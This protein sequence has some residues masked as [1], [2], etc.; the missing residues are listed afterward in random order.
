[1]FLAHALES[2]EDDGARLNALPADVV[3]YRGPPPRR[4]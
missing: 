1:V 4:L 3:D 2:A